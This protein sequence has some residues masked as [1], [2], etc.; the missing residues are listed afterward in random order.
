[1]ERSVNLPKVLH[2][3]ALPRKSPGIM[4]QLAAEREAASSLA[5]PWETALWLPE[6][7]AEL[8]DSNSAARLAHR[9]ESAAHSSS[10]QRF[11]NY[12]TLSKTFFQWLHDVTPDYD[13][14]LI[15]YRVHDPL[16][17]RFI[18][19]SATPVMT[20][21]HAV[22][23][24]ELAVDGATGQARCLAEKMIG[25]NAL[26][27]VSG[28]IGVTREIAVHQAMRS[29][30]KGTPTFL[31]P[32][33]IADSFSVAQDARDD[34][35]QLLFM[36]SYFASWHGIDLLLDSMLGNDEHFL[37]HIV[38]DLS[39]DDLV[40]AGA[41]SRVVL[42]GRLHAEGIREVAAR[43]WLGLASLAIGRQGMTE[44]CPLKTREYLALGLPVYGSYAEVFPR[45][46]PYFI[47]GN[48]DIGD[49]LAA[50]RK[51]RELSRWEIS[52]KARPHISKTRLLSDLYRDLQSSLA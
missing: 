44:A 42:H 49:V 38:G 21:H 22:E 48:P 10:V 30:A 34:R 50:A 52:E 25:P 31:Y 3:S 2:A 5:I 37:L 15:R 19:N 16:L 39:N 33:G 27:R 41:D 29:K 32:N 13:L 7:H 14:L 18:G 26:R 8:H 51:H 45:D 23:V 12:Q 11:L 40:R 17:M 9:P 47:S 35:V 28:L 46:F 20:V 1:M 36:A 4:H 43:C 24:N 6:G